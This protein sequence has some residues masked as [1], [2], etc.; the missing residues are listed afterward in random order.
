M[1][2]TSAVALVLAT[3]PFMVSAA[4]A[5]G[6]TAAACIQVCCDALV[7]GVR[8]PGITGINCTPDSIGDCGFGGQ[9]NACCA[10]IVRD[11][12]YAC[13]PKLLT[14]MTWIQ[15]PNGVRTGTGIGCE[16]F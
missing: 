9:V 13:L 12:H 8:P 1:K 14:A 7:Q 6:A 16:G 3:L 5:A 4:D 2:F 10:R 15:A 11:L